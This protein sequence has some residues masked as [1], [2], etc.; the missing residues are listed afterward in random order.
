[1]LNKAKYRDI[2]KHLLSD[3][4]LQ[5]LRDISRFLSIPHSVQTFLCGE[6]TPTLSAVLPAY[7]DLLIMLHDFQAQCPQ[8][9]GSIAVCIAKIEQYVKKARKTRI[10]A[11]AMS[12]SLF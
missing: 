9:K 10:Y 12:K 1:M 8:L 2:Q 7:E 5:V 11:L 3:M 6:K 4:K